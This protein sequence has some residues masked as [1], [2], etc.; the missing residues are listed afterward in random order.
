MVQIQRL[1]PVYAPGL[2]LQQLAA[3]SPGSF[4]D[5]TICLQVLNV[6]SKG[7]AGIRVLRAFRVLRLFKVFK[8]IKVLQ[9]QPCKTLQCICA[10]SHHLHT[11]AEA[12]NRCSWQIYIHANVLVSLLN[13][14]LSI[15]A[16]SFL[17]ILTLRYTF[18][19]MHRSAE[20]VTLFG[21]QIVLPLLSFGKLPGA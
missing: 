3:G 1:Y 8:Y 21:S 18:R 4:A 20:P 11:L 2:S 14:Q 15:P 16:L 13:K 5:K 19:R 6:S 12:S 7:F 10:I 17:A 9:L